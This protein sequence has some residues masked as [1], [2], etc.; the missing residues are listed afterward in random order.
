M[1]QKTLPQGLEIGFLGGLKEKTTPFAGVSLL[2]DLGRAS[3][4]MAAAEKH[5]PTKKTTKGL[6][7]GQMVEVLV[8]LSALGGECPEDVER[9]RKDEGLEAILGYKLPAA[10]TVRQWLERFHDEDALAARPKQGSFIPAE[11]QGLSGLR[12]AVRYIVR[13]YVATQPTSNEVTL[14]VDAHLVESHKQSA[15]YTYEGFPGFQPVLVSWA[16]TGMVLA[17]EFRDGNVPAGRELDRIV[18]DAYDSLPAR[19]GGWKVRVRSDSAAYDQ[20]IL[21]HWDK[22]EWKF[23]VSA[24]MTPQLRQEIDK[25]PLEAWQPWAVEAKGYVR[26]WAEVPYVPSRTPEKKDSQP[27]R[28][29]AIRIRPP[30]GILFAEGMA[31]KHFAVVTNDWDMAGGSLLE[32]HRGKAGTVEHAHR[33]IKDELAGGVYPSGKFGANA[34]WLRLQVITANLLELLKGTALKEEYR[35]ARPKRLRFAIFS[36]MGRVVSHARQYFIRIA[37][38]FLEGI[39]GPGRRAIAGASWP[40]T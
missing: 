15:L 11:S 32:W 10:P 24:D 39:I 35:R 19:E 31:L 33:V 22:R 28:Y 20:N 21:G 13:A 5:L 36:Q 40:V 9:L 2:V 26:E 29:L 8:L 34:A 17:D 38:S 30:Q 1:P 14:D 37:T 4:V 6:G 16:E 18:D 27:Y 3:G 25:L 7:Q 12:A 23:A